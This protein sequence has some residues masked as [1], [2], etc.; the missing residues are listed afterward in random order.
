MSRPNWDPYD[1]IV[2][3]DIKC[4]M[5]GDQIME[6]LQA[7]Q[8]QAQTIDNLIRSV[9]NLQ[10]AQLQLSQLVTQTLVDNTFKE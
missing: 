9:N 8:L 7:Q 1:V 5:Q 2:Q 6:L 10:Q 4:K 3:L